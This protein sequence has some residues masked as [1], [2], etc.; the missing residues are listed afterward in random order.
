M[1]LLFKAVISNRVTQD[2][3]RSGYENLQGWRWQ[4]LSGHALSS[5]VKASHYIQPELLFFQFK[6][7]V[8][9]TSS[10]NHCEEPGSVF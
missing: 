4:Y 10:I 5:F 2:I 6:P 8:S 9:Y 3:T 1:A 7:I